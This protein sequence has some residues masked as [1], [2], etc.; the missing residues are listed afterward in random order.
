MN[1]YHQSTWSI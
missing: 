1:Q